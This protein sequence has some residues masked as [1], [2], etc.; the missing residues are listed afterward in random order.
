MSGC[1]EDLRVGSRDGEVKEMVWLGPFE[2]VGFRGTGW[3]RLIRSHSSARFCFE[4]SGIRINS[5]I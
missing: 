3:A 1:V 2:L 5:I 4:L